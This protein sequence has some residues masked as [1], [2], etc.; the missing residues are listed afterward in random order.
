MILC[1]TA[2]NLPFETFAQLL[3]HLSI[4][5]PT[6]LVSSSAGES[7]L[8]YFLLC[9]NGS[10]IDLLCQ[11]FLCEYDSPASP[12][13][14]Q[15][16]WLSLRILK[17]RHL[18]VAALSSNLSFRENE[19]CAPSVSSFLTT[20]TFTRSIRE[21]LSV[22]TMTAVNFPVHV[23]ATPL[24]L[25]LQILSKLLRTPLLNFAADLAQLYF[26]KRTL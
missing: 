11:A 24:S 14:P 2:R 6:L 23:L 4:L 22:G 5:H 3:W 16:Q 13:Q 26:H 8:Q 18:S 7:S 21:A 17:Q 20:A 1:S 12:C 10:L 9:L 15:L 25:R 19:E